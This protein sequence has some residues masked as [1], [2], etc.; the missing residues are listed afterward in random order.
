M[1]SDRYPGVIILKLEDHT[2]ATSGQHV[3]RGVELPTRVRRGIDKPAIGGTRLLPRLQSRDPTDP[4]NPRQR[5]HRRR[6]QAH[7]KHLVMHAD[8]PMI[9]PRSLQRRTHLQ[10][11]LLD[12]LRDPGRARPRPSGTRLQHCRLALLH[13][14]STQDI[15]RLTRNRMLRAEHTHRSTRSISRP[16]SNR[17]TNTGINRLVPTHQPIEV[18]P[19][20][21]AKVL[22]M[23]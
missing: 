1:R 14:P 15:E 19:P 8:R 20:T 12:L 2:P 10:R 16:P 6:D 3:L 22:P 17:K 5:R 18:S 21:H 13:C 4:E 23:S 11:L 9:Q 7:R